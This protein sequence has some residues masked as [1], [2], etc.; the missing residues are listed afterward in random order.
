MNH[1]GKEMINMLNNPTIQEV[2]DY[3]A[4]LPQ[5]DK[6]VI[7]DPDTQMYIRK[8]HVKKGTNIISF[9]GE[10]DEM[11]EDKINGRDTNEE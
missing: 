2:I 5:E 10:Y 9:T 1:E 3:L 6:F 4:T 8:I 7:I 11:F